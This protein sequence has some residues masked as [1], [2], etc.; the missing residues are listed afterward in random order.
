ML[1]GRLALVAMV[2]ALLQSATLPSLLAAAKGQPVEFTRGVGGGH[3]SGGQARTGPTESLIQGC[4][5]RFSAPKT[6][7]P[8]VL[9][10]KGNIGSP[11]AELF[12]REQSTPARSAL[13]LCWRA[14][15]IAAVAC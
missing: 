10:G 9:F 7:W 3:Q 14:W 1:G 11:L 15:W 5:S 6:Y 4:I 2:G 13:N 8:D 12:A